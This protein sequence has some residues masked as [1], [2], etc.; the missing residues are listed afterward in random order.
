MPPHGRLAGD[1]GAGVDVGGVHPRVLVGDPRHLALAGAHVGGGHVLGGVDQVALDQFI[2][3]AAGDLLQLVRVVFARVDAQP[4]LGAA[5]RRLDQRA[6]V[7]HQR[8]QRLDLV[9][10]DARVADAALDRLHVFG[11]DRAVAGE[12]LD[13][14]RS[15]TPKRTV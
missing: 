10:V 6:F 1:A 3:E 9:L 2:G 8:G 13:L 15:R 12:G 14:P 4:A 5:E 7:G 11:M